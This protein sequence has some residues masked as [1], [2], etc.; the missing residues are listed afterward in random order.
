MKY[1]KK[2]KTVLIFSRLILPYIETWSHSKLIITNTLKV[3][4]HKLYVI[5]STQYYFS[6]E[7]NPLE[8]KTEIHIIITLFLLFQL[9]S[10]NFCGLCKCNVMSFVH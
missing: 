7:M 1:W 2:K 8:I 10:M 6:T 3:K 4:I 5:Y 9:C